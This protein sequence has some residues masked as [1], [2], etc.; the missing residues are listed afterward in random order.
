MRLVDFKF[1]FGFF[2]FL[3]LFPIAPNRSDEKGVRSGLLPEDKLGAVRSMLADAK[4][5]ASAGRAA[6]VGMVGDG[7]ND[8]PALALATIGIAM[9][10]TGTAVAT[11][12]ADVTSLT[13]V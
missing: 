7:V 6:V 5:G 3:I 12:T 13:T 9:G 10:A 2:L 4:L 1:G 8:A 11:E